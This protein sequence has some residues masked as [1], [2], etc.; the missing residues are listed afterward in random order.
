MKGIVWMM[1]TDESLYGQW[2]KC[3]EIDVMESVGHR[4]GLVFA[5]THWT[6][7]ATGEHAQKGES[8]RGSP[9]DGFHVYGIEWD[10]NRIDYFYDGVKYNSQDISGL[11]DKDGFN[12]FRHPFYLRLNLAFG[13]G[14]GGRM[15]VDDTALPARYEIDYARLYKRVRPN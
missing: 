9:D 12:P 14:W 5:T 7:P 13:G 6:D 15:G 4:P 10:E 3:G 8:F 11:A 1:P 2:P